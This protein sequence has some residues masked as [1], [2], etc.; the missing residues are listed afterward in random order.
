MPQAIW[1][2]QAMWG[3]RCAGMPRATRPLRVAELRCFENAS[4]KLECVGNLEAT[5]YRDLYQEPLIDVGYDYM[6][7]CWGRAGGVGLGF[8]QVQS[9]S[10]LL[11]LAS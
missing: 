5:I 9:Q 4:I 2:F 1:Q 11:F 3:G 10:I 7:T 6:L 8:A